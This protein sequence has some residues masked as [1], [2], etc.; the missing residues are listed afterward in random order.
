MRRVLLG[1]CALAA[2]FAT[3]AAE[4]TV[5][6][7]TFVGLTDS[8]S[9]NDYYNGGTASG[10][11]GP[12]PNYGVGFNNATVLNQVEENE[13]LFVPGPNTIT[14]LSGTGSVMNVAAGF[15][16]GFSFDYAAPFFT[17][18][19]SVFSGLNGTGTLLATINLPETEN[20]SALPGCS[21]HNYCPPSAAG[22]TFAGTA[23]SVNFSGT[24]DFIVY[25]DITLG[26]STVG[27]S[28]T[29]PSG[30]PEPT[31]LAL[32]GGGL[33]GLRFFQ[34]RKKRS[35]VGKPLTL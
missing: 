31:S 11:T 6:D 21:G 23:E 16:T 4:A 8:V 32:F 14:F 22:V 20:G 12:G 27:G 1:S 13:G 28:P 2:L 25:D 30:V 34:R 19:V 35:R 29:P 7:M 3:P 33:L 18:A 24:A 26:S 9:V 5:I 15:T 17:G 10:G